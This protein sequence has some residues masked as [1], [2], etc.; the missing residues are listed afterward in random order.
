MA[1]SRWSTTSARPRSRTSW[2][3]LS[4]RARPGTPIAHSGWARYRSLSGLT[5]SGSIQRPKPSPSSVIRRATPSRPSG[6]LRRSTTQSPSDVVSP[7]RWPNQP[8]S[9]TNSSIPRS[10]ADRAIATSRSASKS[11][12]VASQLLSRTG[13]GR[14]R[15][16]PRARRSR[17]RSWNASDNAPRPVGTWTT[18]A[19][20]VVN[21]SPGARCQAKVSG[22]IPRRTRVVPN[23]V[24]LGLGEEV[25]RVD[26]AATRWPRRGPRPSSAGGARG[27][28]CAARSTSRA[29][30][31]WIATDHERL[32]DDV[33]LARPRPRERDHRPVRVGQVERQAHRRP[34]S[35][36]ASSP[37]RMIA[38]RA[39]TG[40]SA[41]IV[42][43]RSRPRGRSARRPGRSSGSRPPH[44]PRR[45]STGARRARACPGAI[46]DRDTGARASWR[47]R[48]PPPRSRDHGSRRSP[49]SG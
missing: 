14:S 29:C 3:R 43:R 17:Y 10:R 23:D 6:S 22:S 12:Y 9:S 45:R 7:S 31:R 4:V 40:R 49:A 27:T 28:G 30:S 25:A 47:R 35:I 32:F 8:S 2:L 38:L 13:R 37:L 33:G 5:I 11:K 21:A 19:S 48:H 1:P 18:T 15:H 46:R 24:D 20:G 42:Q 16:G 36:G 44:R 34:S 41:K 26:E 39:T